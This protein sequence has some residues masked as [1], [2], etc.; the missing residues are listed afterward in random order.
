MGMVVA[1]PSLWPANAGAEQGLHRSRHSCSGAGHRPECGDV[2]HHLGD[3][4]CADALSQRR[5]AGGRV[6]H[7]QRRAERDPGG[8]FRSVPGWQSKSFQCLDFSSYSILHLTNPDHTDDEHNGLPVTTGDCLAMGT[9]TMFLGR[10]FRPDDGLPGKDHVVVLTNLLWREHF[11]S[12]PNILG[13][14][15]S[16]AD[17]PYIVVG[18]N[19]GR[20]RGPHGSGV[21]CAAGA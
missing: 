13:K 11:H 9:G 21:L 6:D 20:L 19:A 7:G 4:S 17:Q 14:A 5:P 10:D 12:D 16:I 15:I 8:R 3:V 1:G 18:V 2:Q